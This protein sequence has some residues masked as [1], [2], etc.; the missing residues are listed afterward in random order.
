MTFQVQ[1][2]YPGQIVPRSGQYGVINPLGRDTGYEITAVKGERF[3]PY[4]AGPGYGYRLN[5]PT[6]HRR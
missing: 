6:R 1:L 3:P 2:Y 5:D 4:S